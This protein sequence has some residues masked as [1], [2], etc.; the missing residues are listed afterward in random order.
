[1][2]VDTNVFVRAKMA[3]APNHDLALSLIARALDSG[4]TLKISRQTIREFLA[5]VTRPQDWSPS[6]SASDAIGYVREILAIC[7]VL[8]EDE[9]ITENL[10]SLCRNYAVGGRQIH[11][12]NIVATMLAYGERRL[13]TFNE[14][15]FRRYG[16][17]IEL[18][19]V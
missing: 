9:R 1:M 5:V 7:E 8:D 18:V 12:A 13:L 14:S 17:L 15:D 2:F 19:E 3:G 6:L 16:D 4:E 10:L 11:D